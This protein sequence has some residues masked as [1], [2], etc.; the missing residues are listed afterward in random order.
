MK[1]EVVG[2]GLTC[3]CITYSAREARLLGGGGGLRAC[4]PGNFRRSGLLKRL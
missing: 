1:F 2:L 4:F 3:E